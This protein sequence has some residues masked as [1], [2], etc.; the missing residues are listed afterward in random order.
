MEFIAPPT[1]L[2]EAVTE[3]QVNAGIRKACAACAIEQQALAVDLRLV[4]LVCANGQES[5]EAA[6]LKKPRVV[7]LA[8]GLQ[9]LVR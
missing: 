9:H 7:R 3:W 6:E 1:Q 4:K 2:L 5:E 8:D